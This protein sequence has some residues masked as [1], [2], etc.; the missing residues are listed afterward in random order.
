VLTRTIDESHTA[1]S[2]FRTDSWTGET[3]SRPCPW[4]CS[5]RRPS[6][7]VAHPVAVHAGLGGE[8]ARGREHTSGRGGAPDGAPCVHHRQ[9][10]L[11]GVAQLRHGAT[12]DVVF[13]LCLHQL[14]DSVFFFWP[15]D[16]LYPLATVFLLLP[17]R[18]ADFGL[19]SSLFPPT[20]LTVRA[21]SAPA[22][23]LTVYSPMVMNP[24]KPL[25]PNSIL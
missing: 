20:P 22:A 18:P 24:A 11:L 19:P 21:A 16:P 14:A 5:A 10:A 13:Y 15:H 23:K 17:C 12:N 9:D 4:R 3:A 7:A 1:E 8:P 2:I 25:K 6:P